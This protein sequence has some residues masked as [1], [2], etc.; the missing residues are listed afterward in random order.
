[1]G[2]V[3]TAPCSFGGGKLLEETAFSLGLLTSSHHT[4]GS[5]DD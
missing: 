2:V 3:A 4:D 1:V 5:T